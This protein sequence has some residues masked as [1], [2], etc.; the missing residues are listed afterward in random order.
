MKK[1]FELLKSSFKISPYKIKALRG[2]GSNRSFYR[3]YFKNYTLIL[4]LPQ[5]GEYGLNEAK[6]YYELGNFFY[7]HNIPVPKIK[8]W[9][10]EK[11]ILI[12]EDLGNKKL[13]MVKNFLSFYYKILEI[14]SNLQRLVPGFPI[15]K[16]LETPIYNFE[17]LWEKEI[18][19]FLDWYLKKYKN[20]KLHTNLIHEIFLW[21]KEKTN[22]LD[23]VVMHRD[24][25]SKNLM[26]KNNKIF[27]IDFQGARLGPPSYDLAS[28]L[29]DP[30]INHFKNFKEIF[31][32]INYY[33]TLTKYPPEKFY[34][35]FQFLSIIRLMQALAAYCKLFN[36]GKYWFKKYIPIA[37]KKLFKLTKIFFPEIYKMIFNFK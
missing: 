16:T 37:E 29:H 7:F 12:V 35:E 3:L 5:Q 25:Q 14:L 20:I 33:L 21:A 1:I 26:I 11:G 17:F 36:T 15:D 9:D 24:F 23:L 31:K 13:C 10:S 34:K 27:I 28:L 4:I 6:A 8:F 19:Y 32:L 22:F 2:D 30:Y 18:N